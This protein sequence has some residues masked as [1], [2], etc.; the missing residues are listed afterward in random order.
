MAHD[1]RSW[2]LW[3]VRKWQKMLDGREVE[4]LADLAVQVGVDRSYVGRILRLATLAPN[5]M[6][7]ILAGAESS[8]LSLTR[9]RGGL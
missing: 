4:S 5:I 9:L 1:G 2:S 3:L 8:G 6:Q 7:A